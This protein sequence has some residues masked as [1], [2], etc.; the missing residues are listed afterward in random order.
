[1]DFRN[2]G[3]LPNLITCMRLLLVP[4]VISFI[5]SRQWTYAF[6]AFVVAG[7][8]D[9]LDGWIAKTFDWRTELGAYLDPIADKA[10]LVSIYVALAIVGAIP[11][12]LAIIVVARDAM[13]VGAFLVARLMD[14]PMEV[15]PL[16]VSKLNT[17]A[18]ILF[19]AM[20]LSVE[21]FGVEKGAWFTVSAYAVAALALASFAAY[22]LQWIRHM[23]A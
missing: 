10:L 20:V 12:T 18:Q 1:M 13:I 3:S 16:L 17:L 23:G 21:A 7:V 19:A 11:A 6:A 22:S 14:R 8:S 4:A 15:R 2:F 9:G 5:A